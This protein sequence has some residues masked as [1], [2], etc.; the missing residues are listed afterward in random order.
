MRRR[1]RELALEEVGRDRFVVPRVHRRAPALFPAGCKPLAHHRGCHSLLARAVAAPGQFLLDARR[2]VPAPQLREDS[3]HEHVK[4]LL[5][6]RTS[7][8]PAGAKRMVT[9]A[10]EPERTAHERPRVVGLLRRDELE[11]HF[12]LLA[13]KA[14]AFRR[15]SR[16]IVTVFSSRRILV[17]SVRSSLVNGPCGS[18]FSSISAR[19]RANRRLRPSPQG[20]ALWQPEGWSRRSCAPGA[21]PRPCTPA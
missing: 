4:L 10:R 11:A 16:S 5:P 1:G 20:Q 18:R 3:G 13:K 7:R 14:A 6:M 8:R 19:P 17:T 15:K 2:A 12:P 9:G 21:R